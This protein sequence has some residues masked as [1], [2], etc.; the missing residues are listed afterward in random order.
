MDGGFTAVMSSGAGLTKGAASQTNP[1]QSTISIPAARKMVP[2][3]CMFVTNSFKRGFL[4]AR[5][6]LIIARSICAAVI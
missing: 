1:T 2:I 3:R 5:C 6:T 4:R